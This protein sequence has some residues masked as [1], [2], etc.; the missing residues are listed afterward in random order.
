MRE[1]DRVR[2]RH[3]IDAAQAVGRFLHGRT[4]QD[5]STDQLLLFA[6]VH[7]VQVL[8]EAASKVTPARVRHTATFR[9]RPLSACAIALFMPTSISTPISYGSPPPRK[10]RRCCRSWKP[11]F[12][13]KHPCR[14]AC[15]PPYRPPATAGR[16]KAKP[17][18]PAPGPRRQ[19]AS[20]LFAGNKLLTCPPPSTTNS[21]SPFPRAP[22]STW[23]KKTRS[24]MP[25]TPR[26]T[27]ACSSSAWTCRRAPA[28]RT[29]WSRSCCAST[30]MASSASRS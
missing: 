20:S 18:S 23:R 26:P 24:S 3:M 21:W 25:A 11:W 22:C 29:R 16:R 17:Y 27:C 12:D 15:K 6:V 8:G 19:N 9:G 30:T 13:E 7:A 2:V 5:L 28:S 4:R 1:Q 10:F 14:S